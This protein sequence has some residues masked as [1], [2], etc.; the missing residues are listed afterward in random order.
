MF[1]RH[2]RITKYKNKETNKQRNKQ[3]NTNL[4]DD[5]CLMI[6]L[7]NILY[8]NLSLLLDNLQKIKQDLNA[9]FQWVKIN[10]T[11]ISLIVIVPII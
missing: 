6:V 5:D 7:D 1:K 8:T 9:I 2:T 11:D 10:F 3:R 4:F